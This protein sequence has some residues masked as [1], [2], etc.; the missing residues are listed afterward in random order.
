LA[1]QSKIWI[2]RGLEN[3]GAAGGFRSPYNSTRIEPRDN[4]LEHF[5]ITFEIL[6]PN[7]HNTS[8]Q[9]VWKLR[10]SRKHCSGRFWR[11]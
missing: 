6:S 2:L 4:N 5:A 11:G 1:L 3:S 10:F 8:L 9:I 7:I